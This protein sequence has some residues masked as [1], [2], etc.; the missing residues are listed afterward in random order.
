MGFADFIYA[1]LTFALQRPMDVIPPVLAFLAALAVVLFTMPPLI[2]KMRD[3]GMVGHDV[4]KRGR[5]TVAEL[6][7][8]AS[9]F[10]FSIS[11]SLV[12]G[13]EKLGPGNQWEP[14]YLAAISVFFIASMIGLIDDISNIRQRVKAVAVVF[15]SLPLLLVHF[16]NA[17]FAAGTTDIAAN[18]F[19][20]LPF[21]GMIDFTAI[22]YLYW[23]I[24]VPI[25][26]TGVANAMNM[27]AGYNGLES[28]QIAVVSGSL[29]V[30]SVLRG[31][32]ESV[33]I[34]S[35][36]LGAALGLYWFNRHP[37]KVFVGDIG[38]LGL[39]AAI[40][41]GAIIGGIEA[42]GL[43]AIAPAFYEAGATFYYGVVKRN[44]NRREAC[45]SPHIARDG[46]LSPPKGAERYTLAYL[47]L[48]RK[49]MKEPRLVATLLALYALCGVAAILLSLV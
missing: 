45:H 10:A 16:K 29:L 37:A 2:R 13:L 34:F 31:T 40:A 44:G 43:I 6:G 20:A 42:W 46:T 17:G 15:A 23:F 36:L 11:L 9:L 27:S 28:G 25:G 5:P 22:P 3:G 18:A 48:S 47:L 7:G 49:P 24:L 1:T 14:P 19:I 4:N 12:V 32:L 30:V 26:V 41:A 8:I 39:G 38:T 35:A 21:S 33:L